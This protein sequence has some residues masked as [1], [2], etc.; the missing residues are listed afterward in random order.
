MGEW[1]PRCSGEE[2]GETLKGTRENSSH[3]L[4]G[5]RGSDEEEMLTAGRMKIRKIKSKVRRPC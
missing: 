1:P 4:S 3:R 5:E 2:E